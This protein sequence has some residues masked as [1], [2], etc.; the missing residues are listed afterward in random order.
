LA[1]KLSI[2]EEKV[3]EIAVRHI[4]GKQ[5][6][7]IET[8]AQA[9]N[10]QFFSGAQGFG[11]VWGIVEFVSF[12]GL[13]LAIFILVLLIISNLNLNMLGFL[14]RQKEIGSILAMGGTPFFIFGFLLLEM[15]IFAIL[16]FASAVGVFF[17]LSQVFALQFNFGEMSLFFAGNPLSLY[18]ELAF[19]QQAF[20]TILFTLLISAAYP[21]YL[22]CKINP[23][24]VFREAERP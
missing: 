22:S 15:L 3:L 19:I 11:V 18:F 13:F 24:E 8:M 5:Q 2:P 17:L 6:E 16:I 10:L 14:E 23:I 20:L 7:N 12:I 4:D 21:L 9:E 1:L